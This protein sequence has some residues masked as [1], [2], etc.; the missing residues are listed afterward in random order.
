MKLLM[1]EVD[2]IVSTFATALP[3]VIGTIQGV[4][5]A[6]DEDSLRLRGRRERAAH[7][8]RQIR[9]AGVQQLPDGFCAVRERYS[10]SH[11]R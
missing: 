7:P 9:Y 1:L 10:P 11:S 6:G 8:G 5:A 3:A 4:L 2:D